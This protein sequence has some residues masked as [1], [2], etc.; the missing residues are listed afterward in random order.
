MQPQQSDSDAL[1]LKPGHEMAAPT[2][3]PRCTMPEG[4][5]GPCN[6]AERMELRARLRAEAAS[7]IGGEA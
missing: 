5:N 2:F 1:C 7:T 3:V 4:H 6:W